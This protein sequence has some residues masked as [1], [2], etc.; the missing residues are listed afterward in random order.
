MPRMTLQTRL[1]LTSLLDDPAREWYGLALCD[2]VG[3]ASGT[4]YPILA[5][6]EGEGWLESTWEDPSVHEAEGR[7]RRRLYRLTRDGAELARAALART[8][9]RV[10]W[11]FRAVGPEGGQA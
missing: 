10:G 8:E 11:A 7:P 9:R 1:V 3:L 6:L 2:A 4:I 5:R